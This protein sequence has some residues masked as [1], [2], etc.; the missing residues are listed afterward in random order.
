MPRY[1][2]HF[3]AGSSIFRDEVG[4]VF[5]DASL[6]L[7]HAKRIALEL[8]RGGEPANAA[9]IVSE[10]DRQLYI[11]PL[12]ETKLKPPPR[13]KAHLLT[14][15]TFGCSSGRP[16]QEARSRASLDAGPPLLRLRLELPRISSSPL[17]GE[18]ATPIRPRSV[19]AG[20]NIAAHSRRVHSS[21][22]KALGLRAQHQ[23]EP[24]PPGLQ[25]QGRQE[26]PDAI[27]RPPPSDS[28][29]HRLQLLRQARV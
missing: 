28:Q 24:L 12:T 15:N 22:N 23:E 1:H 6:A 20:R 16:P 25:Q 10:D 2:F 29:P 27:E 26:S 18:R 5:A 11:V 3:R 8:A 13:A 4:D 14:P 19:R 21:H 9:T 7:Q 17:H